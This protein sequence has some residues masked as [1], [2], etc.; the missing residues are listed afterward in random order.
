VTAMERLIA[1]DKQSRWLLWIE[2]R[3]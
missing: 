2:R 3:S 1:P